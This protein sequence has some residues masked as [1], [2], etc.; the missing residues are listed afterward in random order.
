MAQQ[1]E[2]VVQHIG[3]FMHEMC[4]SRV[5]GFSRCLDHFGALFGELRADLVDAAPE[6]GCGVGPL[7]R[8]GFA[9]EDDCHQTLENL[10]RAVHSVTPL[11]CEAHRYNGKLKTIAG[12]GTLLA[13]ELPFPA[14]T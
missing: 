7:R 5:A 14:A 6:Q 8:V 12:K 4:A 3:R 9:V 11:H 2:Q 13:T 10:R 1:H